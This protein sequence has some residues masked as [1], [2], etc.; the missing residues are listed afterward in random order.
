MAPISSSGNTEIGRHIKMVNPAWISRILVLGVG[1]LGLEVLESLASHP[2][3]HAL[4][5]S[6]T[7]VVSPNS[8]PD[9][10][11]LPQSKKTTLDHL[12]NDLDISILPQ[13]LYGGSTEQ[14]S[15]VFNSYDTVVSCTGMYAPSGIQR[16]ITQAVL[17]A[18]QVSYF[19]PW[20]FGVDYDIIGRGSAQDL[21]T[22]QL[23]V[24]A[25]LR[26]Q[27]KTNW[28]IV[29]T[30]LFMSFLFEP[31]FGVVDAEEKGGTQNTTVRALGDWNYELTATTVKDIGRCI[32][33]IIYGPEEH[34]ESAATNGVIFLAGDTLN[35]NQLAEAV[36]DAVGHRI[37]RQL[38]SLPYLQHELAEDP[39]NGLIKYRCI[40]AEGRGVAW[41]KQQSFNG[42]FGIEMETASEYAATNLR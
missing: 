18:P 32:A 20:Q 27:H 1:E 7:A 12:T 37:T 23:D 42:R 30:G 4:N 25:L 38:W 2:G 9:N 3:R 22:E 33:E 6:I 5:A 19:I 16:K 13:D 34:R 15:S 39:G 26:G 40:W 17:S 41:S 31:A 28:N 21:F 14:L 11:S 8:A 29:S 10:P 35:Y 36:E 24:R